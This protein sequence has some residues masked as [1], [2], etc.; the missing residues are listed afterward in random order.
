MKSVYICMCKRGDNQNQESM[1]Q[2]PQTH[3]HIHIYTLQLGK[4]WKI[5][6]Y[7][8]AGVKSIPFLKGSS[9]LA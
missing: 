8:L 4:S 7:H 9:S 1:N 5:A 3:I 6:L 2:S